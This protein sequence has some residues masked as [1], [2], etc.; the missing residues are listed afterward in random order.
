MKKVN[1]SSPDTQ[2]VRRTTRNDII[3]IAALL[4]LILLSALAVLLF[5]TEG[6]TVIVS[7]DGNNYGEYPLNT[8]AEIEIKNGDGYNVLVI[9]DGEAYV[10]DASCPDGICSS[11]RPIRYNGQSIVCLPNKVVIEIRSQDQKQPD[12][13]A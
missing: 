2:G 13:I 5:R 4:T 1:K 6:D 9:K 3:L 8:D 7:V 10:R 12:I 11:H